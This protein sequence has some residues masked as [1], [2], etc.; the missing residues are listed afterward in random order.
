[1]SD[2]KILQLIEEKFGKPKAILSIASLGNGPEQENENLY[3]QG[4]P[5]RKEIG[6]I[7]QS[8]KKAFILTKLT[9]GLC[10]DHRP[11]IVFTK[12]LTAYFSIII[13]YFI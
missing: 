4:S 11:E 12:V 10:E 5:T 1:M 13:L 7:F 3:S 2:K 8:Y 9:G 6:Q